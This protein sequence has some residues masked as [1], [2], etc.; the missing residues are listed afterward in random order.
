MRNVFSI[1]VEDWFHI[2]DAS[3]APDIGR[4]GSMESRVEAN[5]SV[6]L[7]MLERHG[8]TA[9]FFVLGWIAEKYPALVREIA[10]AGHEIANHGHSHTLVYRIGREEFRSDLRRA[11]DALERAAGTRPTG[12]RAPGFSIT[13]G[14]PWAFDV[15]AEEGYVYD[16]S[17]FPAH[18]GHGGFP[19]ASPLPYRMDNGL[20]ELPVSTVSV[21]L[22]RFA[23]A[24]GGYLRLLPLAAIRRAATSHVK[25]GRPIILYVHPR[26]IDKDQPRISLP[27]H[28]YFKC[29]VGLAGCRLKL[30]R[31]LD[32]YSWG[33]FRDL[34]P[35]YDPA[36]ATAPVPEGTP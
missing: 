30:E 2:L 28:R 24:G 18:R 6:L 20:L 12:Y 4:W 34:L 35:L 21:I 5:T 27:P 29:Y 15:L 1:D 33:S 31:L 32:S 3:S 11:A 19:G 8:V 17:V 16:S 9:T 13:A 10:A 25:R 36:P 7:R 14:T 22:G 23:F 26:D